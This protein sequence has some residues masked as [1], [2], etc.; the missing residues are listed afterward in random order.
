[1]AMS[2][3]KECDTTASRGS[4]EEMAAGDGGRLFSDDF[5]AQL[6][7]DQA[8]L[9]KFEEML[10]TGLQRELGRLEQA[11]AAADCSAAGA[12]AHTFKGL[13]AN[14]RW[15]RPWQLAKE[16]EQLLA[17]GRRRESVAC[18]ERLRAEC[19]RLPGV[20]NTPADTGE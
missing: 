16:L 12:A 11:I 8:A 5:L 18:W 19:L 2:V 9:A 10:R 13:A 6:A 17:A 3:E 15:K 7:G 1:M 20:E 14:L 4:G